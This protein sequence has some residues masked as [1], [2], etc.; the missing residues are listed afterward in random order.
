VGAST[1]RWGWVERRCGMWSSQRE[2]G[3]W[4]ME[5]KNELQIKLNL[6]KYL[7]VILY[8]RLFLQTIVINLII[9]QKYIWIRLT[10]QSVNF[11]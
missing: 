7:Q 2:D 10:S 8:N 3:E 1:W 11:K 5:C 6:K 9:N 4:N